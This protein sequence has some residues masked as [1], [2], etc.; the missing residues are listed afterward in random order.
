MR[1]GADVYFVRIF[2]KKCVENSKV[3]NLH[4]YVWIVVVLGILESC[5]ISVVVI[6]YFL[7]QHIFL[8]SSLLLFIRV[9]F[10]DTEDGVH[11]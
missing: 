10:F 2:F 9:K 11:Y 3:Q 5:K 7:L 6:R 8:H 1:F 4:R